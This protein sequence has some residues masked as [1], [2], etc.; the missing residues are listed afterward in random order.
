VHYCAYLA[1]WLSAVP[2]L[3]QRIFDLYTANEPPECTFN[4][5]PVDYSPYYAFRCHQFVTGNIATT[6]KV[7]PR[8]IIAAFHHFRSTTGKNGAMYKLQR[9]LTEAVNQTAANRL[10]TAIGITTK[11]LA[12]LNA[13]SAKG[14][15][16]WLN[17]HLTPDTVMACDSFGICIRNRLGLSLVNHSYSV[18]GLCKT[19]MMFPHH[20]DHF[21]SCTMSSK[22]WQNRHNTVLRALA[23]NARR[24]DANQIKIEPAAVKGTD[25]A[26]RPDLEVRTPSVSFFTDVTVIHPCNQTHMRDAAIHYP[27]PLEDAEDLKADKHNKYAKLQGA[28]FWPFACETHGALG[29][30][31]KY[32]FELI[33][34][35]PKIK[36]RRT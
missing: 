15:G 5:A 25:R 9:G 13:V 32:Y 10:K 8:D 12:R 18:C 31:T 24:F 11:D 34:H 14:A 23:A 21:L 6:D 22:M 17:A 1:S 27:K 30:A 16:R 2:H 28:V 33:K 20:T 7:L 29:P 36:T 35:V 26:T 4:G 19:P 3:P